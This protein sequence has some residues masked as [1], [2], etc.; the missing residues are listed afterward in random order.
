[1]LILVGTNLLIVYVHVVTNV[2]TIHTQCKIEEKNKLKMEN[3]ITTTQSV[4]CVYLLKN[5]CLNRM[6]MLQNHTE[7]D[8]LNRFFVIVILKTIY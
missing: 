3:H 6:R 1:M 7:S 5:V 2:R 8:R 4:A